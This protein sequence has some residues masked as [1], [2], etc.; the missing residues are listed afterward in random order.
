[1]KL[2]TGFVIVVVYLFTLLGTPARAAE[3][4]KILLAH[5]A[6]K[7]FV[8]PLW[9]AK[10]QGFFKKYGLDVDL[11]FIIAGQI[12]HSKMSVW[13]SPLRGRPL[14]PYRLA[15]FTNR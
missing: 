10:E 5:G 7:N 15:A 3:P 9:I 13:I 14:R 8:E 4:T 12:E 6:I 1:M 11:V 2:W